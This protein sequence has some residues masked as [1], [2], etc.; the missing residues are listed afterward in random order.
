MTIKKLENI[1]KGFDAKETRER[2]LLVLSLLSVLIFMWH[3]TFYAS[4]IKKQAELGK[5]LLA[6]EKLLNQSSSIEQVLTSAIEKDPNAAKRRELTRL[7]LEL[8]ELDQDL[9]EMSVGL[10]PADALV[11]VLHDVLP[12][13]DKTR[14]VGVKTIAPVNINFQQVNTESQKSSAQSAAK[15]EKDEAI[16]KARGD[17]SKAESE[18]KDSQEVNI[19]RADVFKHS[20]EL[21]LEANYFS[22]FSYLE[23]LESL[24]WRLYWESLSYE[25]K[26]YPSARVR[27][28]VYTLSADRGRLDD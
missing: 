9:T 12:V 5:R 4:H 23:A 13:S 7:K 14:I 15:N 27:V 6:T 19:V 8:G 25:V 28:S 11:R 20:V 2:V 21:E 26:D 17:K 18:T 1:E 3:F 22:L 16:A 10:V 24:P